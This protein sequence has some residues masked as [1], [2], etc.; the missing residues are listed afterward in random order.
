MGFWVDLVLVHKLTLLIIHCD[1]P[2]SFCYPTNFLKNCCFAS[3]GPSYDKNTKMGAFESLPTYG[4]FIRICIT[5]C[6]FQ[7]SGHAHDVLENPGLELSVIAYLSLR[8]RI[9]REAVVGNVEARDV[10]PDD[11]CTDDECTR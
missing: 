6:T 2:G 8:P 5:S 9:N 7:A 3:I 1:W 10:R 11:N 4:C